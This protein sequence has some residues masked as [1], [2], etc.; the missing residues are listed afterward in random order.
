MK[1]TIRT[2]A[3]LAGLAAMVLL[4]SGHLTAADPPWLD[5]GKCEACAPYM[6]E[7]GLMKNADM[8]DYP[9]ATGMVSVTTVSPEFAEALKRAHSKCENVVMRAQNGENVYLCG[10]CSDLLTLA[11]EGAKI[12][13]V[14]TKTGSLMAVTSSDPVLIQKIHAHVDRTKAAMKKMA[15]PSK[16]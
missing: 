7:P 5:M 1:N 12:D 8:A 3:S 16:S 11:G 2:A 4:F 13:Q 6:A 9:I 14:E 15:A 10:M